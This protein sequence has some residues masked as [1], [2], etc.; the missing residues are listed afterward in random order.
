MN[1]QLFGALFNWCLFGVLVVQLYVYSYNFPEDNK[2][3]KLLVYGICFLETLQTALTGADLYYCPFDVPI[4]E[5]VVSLCVQFFFSYRI[6]VLSMKQTWWLSLVICLFSVVEAVAAFTGGIYAHIHGR[7]ASIARTTLLPGC[8][9]KCLLTPC[10]ADMAYR[11]HDGRLL[12]AA[13]MLFYRRER[14]CY[15]GDHILRRVVRLTIET[16]IMTGNHRGTVS[17]V[18]IAA[19]PVRVSRPLAV[20]S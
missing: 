19:F 18:L 10:H 20:P 13:A 8:P 6:W 12:I 15:N 9:L 4:I 1:H 3:F 11:E 14:D 5:S 2:V 7:F 16:N 17:L